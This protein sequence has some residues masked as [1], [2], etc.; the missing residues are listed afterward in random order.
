MTVAR[1]L[2]VVLGVNVALLGAVELYH[3]RALHRVVRTTERLTDVSTR[4][5]LA[6]ARQNERIVSLDES[7]AKYAVTRDRGYLTKS[8]TVRAEF[9]QEL[10]NLL[11]LPVN[12]MERQALRDVAHAWQQV[13]DIAARPA[14]QAPGRSAAAQNAM[15][16]Q[17]ALDSLRLAGEALGDA[18]Q[19]AMREGAFASR[20]VADTA[21]RVSWIAAA[22]ALLVALISGL[23]LR[24]S[25]TKPLRALSAGTQSVAQGQFDH[26][27]QLE[28]SDEFRQV[29]GA[30]NTMT[31]RLGELDRMKREFVSNVSHDLKSPLASLRET[32]SLLLDEVPG[33]LRDSQRRVLLLQRESADRLGV[34]I[35]KLLDLSRIEAGLPLQYESIAV[36]SFMEN[37]VQHAQASGHERGIRIQL[38]RNVAASV[39]LVA[40]ADRVRQLVDNLLENAVK[41]SPRSD[42]VSVDLATHGST[43]ML[44]VA[45]RGPGVEREDAERV[46]DRFYQTAAGRAVSGRGTGLGLTICRE[47]VHAHGGHIAVLARDGGGSVFVVKLPGLSSTVVAP[48]GE[49]AA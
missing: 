27:L 1:R 19:R 34:M 22:G 14:L 49:A 28:W 43:L 21:E 44:S 37:A 8:A 7:L 29:A 15:D 20:A 3:L 41:F 16:L 9:S 42:V 13:N 30:F 26:R 33:P 12:G 11:A 40:D 36:Q 31:A 39:V 6:Q 24:R 17:R 47:V 45:D 2:W 5:V 46:F 32:T 48:H 35:A 23:A 25:I 18:S 4:V 10:D 38:L